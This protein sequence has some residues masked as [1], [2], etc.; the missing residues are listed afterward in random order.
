MTMAEEKAA[1]AKAEEEAKAAAAEAQ[2]EEEKRAAFAKMQEAG[3]EE[4]LRRPGE[5]REEHLRRML[6]NQRD[7]TGAEA[8]GGRRNA[9]GV[10]PPPT[11]PSMTGIGITFRAVDWLWQVAAIKQGYHEV[12]AFLCTSVGALSRLTPDLESTRTADAHSYW[13][14]CWRQ[15]T[16][17]SQYK[18]PNARG[19]QKERWPP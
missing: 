13:K 7:R 19:K 16:R 17:S 4:D 15:G 18:A 14:R 6:D 11:T 9:N 2:K 8:A 5:S 3:A 10:P 12:R 1:A